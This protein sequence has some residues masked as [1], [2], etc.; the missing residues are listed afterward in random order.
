MSIPRAQ[1]APEPAQ[2]HQQLQELA[3]AAQT[4]NELSDQLTKFVSDIEASVN[5]LNIG[6]TANV[7]TEQW[8]DEEGLSTTIWRLSYEKLSK[9]WGFAIE[10]LT[11]NLRWGPEAE[12]Y[13]SWAFKDAPREH[14]MQAVEKIPALLEALLEKSKEVASEIS[15]RVNYAKNLAATLN[16][17]K[18][19]G[20]TK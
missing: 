18:T 17:E 8:S 9:Q 19:D 13:E 4:L 7:K 11:E 3:S 16:Q 5:K 20:A 15:G 10:R 12:T 14:R 6:V 2:I 1:L